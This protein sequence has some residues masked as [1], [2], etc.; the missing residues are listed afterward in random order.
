MGLA[1][2]LSAWLFDMKGSLYFILYG[3]EEAQTD[4][5]FCPSR[6]KKIRA[7]KVNAL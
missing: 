1:L 3:S 5:A 6:M 7:K 2:L 4:K